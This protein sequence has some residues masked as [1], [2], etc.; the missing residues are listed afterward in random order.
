MTAPAKKKR[1][2]GGGHLNGRT[3]KIR[4]VIRDCHGLPI[5][6]PEIAALVG[7]RGPKG[8][9]SVASLLSMLYLRGE[10]R[11][12]NQAG[13]APDEHGCTRVVTMWRFAK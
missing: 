13:H 10:L 5:S 11:K 9:R 12:F 6:T 4:D 1:N 2:H 3:Q 7:A 8:I